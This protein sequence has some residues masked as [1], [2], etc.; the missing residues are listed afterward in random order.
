[1]DMFFDNNVE[2]IFKCEPPI[3][4]LDNGHGYDGVLLRNKLTDTLQCHI[5]GN[6]FKALSHHVI[7]SHKISCDDYRDNYKLPYKFPLVGRS[8]SKSHSDNANRKISLENLAKHRNPDYARK[9]SPLNNKKRWDY[10]YKRLGN[11]NIVGAC[12]E[13]LRQRYMLVS[14][15]VGRNPTYRDLLKH[16]SK[17]VKLI[18]NRYK[19]LNLFRE[20]NGFEVVEP[21]RPVNGISDDSCINALR[22]F[23]KKYRRV[24]TSRDFRSLTP[25]TKTFIDHFGSWNR[26]L[27]IAGFIR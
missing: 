21:N 8:I 1:M 19:S 23:Y 16:D 25:T 12:P 13:Q 27:K 22:I 15:Y 11:D 14:D 20:Q 26:S 6:W 4:K 5:C 24:P 3:K 7:F 10:I 9:F 2:T 17:I 18:K